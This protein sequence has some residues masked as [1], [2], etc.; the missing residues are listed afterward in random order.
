MLLL[1]IKFEL[2]IKNSIKSNKNQSRIKPRFFVERALNKWI[3]GHLTC[4]H[5]KTLIP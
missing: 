5:N 4:V 1:F 3:L 2:G